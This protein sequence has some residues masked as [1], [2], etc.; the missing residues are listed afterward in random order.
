M[1]FW[2]KRLVRLHMHDNS[3]SIDG[4]LVGMVADHYQLKRP[5]LVESESSSHDLRGEA[6]IDRRRVLF[7]QVLK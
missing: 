7:V 5:V 3:P 2:R 6:W 4:F 1:K